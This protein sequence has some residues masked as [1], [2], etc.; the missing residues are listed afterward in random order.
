MIIFFASS[1]EILFEYLSKVYL[2]NGF[3]KLK[4]SKNS[5]EQFRE[6]FK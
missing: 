2:T 1:L 3:I 4:L 5:I 6:A